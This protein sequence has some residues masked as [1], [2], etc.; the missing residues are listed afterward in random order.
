[1][2]IRRGFG[3]TSVGVSESGVNTCVGDCGETVTPD[4]W[5]A[6]NM[7]TPLTC[8]EIIKTGAD[9]SG[10]TCAGSAAGSLSGIISQY[11]IYIALGLA[12]AALFA[13]GGRRR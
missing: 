1:M 2:I 6:Q 10:T 5:F 11:G 13:A 4:S 12:A 9:V 8:A 7:D 3:A